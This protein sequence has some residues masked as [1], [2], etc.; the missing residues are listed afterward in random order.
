[1]GLIKYYPILITQLQRSELI[2]L[3][4]K[5]LQGFVCVLQPQVT[6][7]PHARGQTAEQEGDV[8]LDERREE[9][10]HAVDGEGDEE[11]LPSADAVG[12]PPPHEG[13]DHHP[14]V[15]DQTCGDTV[16]RKP[17]GPSRSCC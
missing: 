2:P 3:I 6:F 14:Q 17:I 15:H 4:Y 16:G 13:P 5:R 1:M 7:L 8:A 11:R 9:S 12:Q 10:K